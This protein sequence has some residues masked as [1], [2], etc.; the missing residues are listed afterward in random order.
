MRYL[1]TML[2]GFT[3][4]AEAIPVGDITAQTVAQ[5]VLEHWVSRYG[6]PE[7]IHSDQGAQFTGTLFSEVMEMLDIKKT[8]T[9]PYNPR[10]NKVER[11]HRVLGE[12]IRSD[13]TRPA[14]SWAEKLPAALFAYR[15]TVSTVTGVTP[16]QALFGING[17]VPLDVLFPTPAERLETWSEFIEQSRTKIRTMHQAMREK[18]GIGIGRAA[19]RARREQ[20]GEKYLEVGD[21]VYYFSPQIQRSGTGQVHRKFAILWTGPYVVQ[22]KVSESLFVIYPLGNWAKRPREIMAVIDKLSKI[23]PELVGKI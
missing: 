9:P 23:K 12:I 16:F 13:S 5:V 10:S 22:K 11:F 2:D 15:T 18:I 7:Q 20:R 4:W 19:E 1:V 14:D 6:I 3:K 17:R 21:H 8:V